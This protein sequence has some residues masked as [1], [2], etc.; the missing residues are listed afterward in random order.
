VNGRLS[1]FGSTVTQRTSSAWRAAVAHA[2]RGWEWLRQWLVLGIAVVLLICIGVAVVVLIGLSIGRGAVWLWTK[3]STHHAAITPLL[4]LSAGVAVAGV[5]L[6]RHFAQTDADRQQRI[7][8]SFSKAIEQL[9]SDKVEVRLGGIYSLERIS[10]ESPNDYWTVMENL[11]AFL[12]EHSRRPEA[13]RTE[14][15][16]QR[17]YF[18]WV[19]AGRPEGSADFFWAK[20][21]EWDEDEFEERPPT[22]IA[23]ILT[24]LTRR[25]ERDRKRESANDWRLDLR[26]AILRKAYLREAHLEGATLGGVHLEGANLQGAHLEGAT[27]G[28]A[29]LEGANLRDAHLEGANLRD[30]HLEKAKLGGALLIGADL[31]N[32]HLEGADLESALLETYLRG[33]HLERTNLSF[34]SF[35]EIILKDKHE[36][37][38]LHE[39][40]GRD[41]GH[42]D[43]FFRSGRVSAAVLAGAHFEGADLKQASLADA[44]LE[45]ADLGY[46]L[47]LSEEQLRWAIGNAATRLPDGLLRPAHWAP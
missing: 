13:E 7:T 1:R 16:S 31:Q 28:G 25:G 3:Y 44:H 39:L 22:D 18:L 4:T 5:A 35:N 42:F 2:E 11:A 34:A 33:A 8:E 6:L 15:I 17:A 37:L 40:S 26:A 14:R 20:A 43:D 29:H 10:K 24:V 38:R 41:L 32:A 21:V 27:L 47:G 45:G 23:A 12:R 30:A 36:L 19:E 9:G 46:A